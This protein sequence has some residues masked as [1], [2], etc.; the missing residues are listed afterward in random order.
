MRDGRTSGME[1]KKGRKRKKGGTAREKGHEAATRR[2]KLVREEGIPPAVKTE[3]KPSPTRA[4]RQSFL[5]RRTADRH[6]PSCWRT[7]IASQPLCPR[8][9]RV[10]SLRTGQD[11]LRGGWRSGGG[12]RQAHLDALVS[13]ELHAGAPVYS[14]APIAPEQRGRT[15]LERMQQHTDLAR[16]CR[17]TAIPLT[18]LAQRTGTTTANAGAI[19]HAQAAIGFSALLMREQLLVS[20]ATQRPIGL[21]SKVLAGEAARFPGQAHLRGSIARG[22]SRVTVMEAG[23]QEQIRSCAPGQDEADAPVPGAG[24]RPIATPPASTPAPRRSGCTSDRGPARHP[25]RPEQ[26]QRHRDA[27]TARPHRRR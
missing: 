9:A 25:H 13:H 16:L 1:S 7:R 20:G 6:L 19:H 15:H 27:D 5:G 2:S 14:P 22:G 11:H 4:R 8:E 24:S 3:V 17:R 12:R 26:A 10:R 21:E 18:L 23:E